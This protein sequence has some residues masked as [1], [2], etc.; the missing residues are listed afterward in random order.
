MS[1]EN[2]AKLIFYQKLGEL[3][4]AI[5]ATDKIVRKEEYKVLTQLV[6][7]EWTH[8]IEYNEQDKTDAGYQIS[9]VFEWFDYERLDAE[10]CFKSFVNYYKQH[11][12]FFTEERKAL[13]LTTAQKI[14][15]AFSGYN[16]SE[17][18]MVTKLQLLFKNN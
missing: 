6:A 8:S 12:R 13:L 17:L 15:A 18:I 11:Q 2:K 9:I 4:Y 7:K 3:F 10:D 1:K 5:A 14:A 16:K